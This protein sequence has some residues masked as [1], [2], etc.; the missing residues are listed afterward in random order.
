[1][2]SRLVIVVMVLGVIAAGPFRVLVSAPTVEAQGV[3]PQ[4]LARYLERSGL[5]WKRD[6][7]DQNVFR[8]TKESGLKRASRVEIVVTNIPDKNLVTVRSFP[9]ANGKYLG[10]SQVSDK[11]G[12]MNDMLKRNATAFGAYFLD[13][14]GD[15]GFRFIFTTESGLG[16][17]AFKTVL[18][19]HLRIADEHIVAL[20]QKYR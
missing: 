20:Y 17:T 9:Q 3:T 8:V 13:S 6:D 5:T 15:F 7:K 1:M 11:Q 12:L 4:L 14:E 19:E 16:Y 18:D 10:L 2:R